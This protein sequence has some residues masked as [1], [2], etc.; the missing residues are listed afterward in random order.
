MNNS[1]QYIT[2]TPSLTQSILLKHI[3]K[4][5]IILLDYI[6][7]TNIYDN[8]NALLKLTEF[9]YVGT[10]ITYYFGYIDRIKYNISK[11]NVE[12]LLANTLYVCD[13]LLWSDIIIKYYNINFS[14]YT[15]KIKALLNSILN[16]I[17]VLHYK[18][19]EDT[20][21]L[22]KK[23]YDL[24]IVNK[25]LYEYVEYNLKNI[26]KKYFNKIK[27][28]YILSIIFSFEKQSIVLINEPEINEK[29]KYYLKLINYQI[30]HIDKLSK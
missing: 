18:I 2:Y 9:K 11:D 5:N 30:K 25:A 20:K 27:L 8:D 23:K 10:N 14:K 16:E 15:D 21:L 22:F 12:N 1:I 7:D 29:I 19:L 24:D 28:F 6:T 17:K 13:T 3:N 4:N 26:I